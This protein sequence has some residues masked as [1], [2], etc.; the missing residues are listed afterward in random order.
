[1]IPS[2]GRGRLGVLVPFTNSN[3]EPDFELMRP[4]GLSCHWSRMGG[5]D[6]DAVPDEDQMQALGAS[7]VNG[8]LDLLLGIKPD[9][10]VYGCTSA[11]LTHG[12]A[13]DRALAEKI[14]AQSGAKTVTAAGAIVHAL[15]ALGAK[16]IGF[17]SPYVPAINDLAV[18]FLADMGF[19]VVKR[20][21]VTEALGNHEQGALDP[22]AV[23]EL[24]LKADSPGSD[25]I[26][27]SCTEMRSVET[28]ARLEA[29]LGKPVVSSNQAMMYQALGALNVHDPI[30]GFGALLENVAR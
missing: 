8:P 1:M 30:Y 24:G 18:R 4:P 16:H 2:R 19:E 13:F 7:D 23:Y 26:V 17:A 9:V 10:V 28:I 5:Y 12:P 22:E 14:T 20:S 11:T 3:L 21:E 25:A 27:L 29:E 15:Q 6:E